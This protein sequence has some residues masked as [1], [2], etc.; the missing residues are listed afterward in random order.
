MGGEKAQHRQGLCVLRGSPPRGRG[1]VD[2]VPV[3]QDGNWI[4][5]AWAGKSLTASCRKYTLGITPAW[6]GKSG[7]GTELYNRAKDH[8]RVG[9]E[10]HWLRTKLIHG[11]GSP[12]R[13][14]G[15]VSGS[16]PAWR[17]DGITPAWAGKSGVP[18]I[19]TFL[20]MDHPRVGGEKLSVRLG[21]RCLCGSPPRGR[22][23]AFRKSSKRNLT[24][25]TPAWAGKSK[26]NNFNVWQIWDHP[27]VGGEKLTFIIVKPPFLGSPPR[28]RGKAVL[29]I[30]TELNH[31]ITPAWAGK[32]WRSSPPP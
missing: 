19:F 6:A 12:P 3:A 16:L 18:G 17:A 20:R 25:I 7:T 31:G 11:A 2:L 5:P 24:R 1:K 10:K 26:N 8:P 32:R 21:I 22:G 30:H 15:K 9:G 13:G 29:E 27:R 14:R 23:K 4:T 28:G